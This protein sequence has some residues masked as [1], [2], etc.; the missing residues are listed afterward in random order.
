MNSSSSF[1]RLLHSPWV[2]LRSRPQSPETA[3]PGNWRLLKGCTPEDPLFFLGSRLRR[4]ESPAQRVMLSAR[5][6]SFGV[7]LAPLTAVRVARPSAGWP[8]LRPRPRATHRLACAPA[9][10]R[11][12]GGAAE[13][14]VAADAARTVAQAVRRSSVRVSSA[15]LVRSEA[16]WA[17]QNAQFGRPV[18]FRLAST[19]EAYTPDGC[20]GPRL[21]ASPGHPWHKRQVGQD[22]GA[23]SRPRASALARGLRVAAVGCGLALL[24]SQPSRPACQ[25]GVHPFDG[26]G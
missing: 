15:G 1:S 23:A 3:E 13:Q 8:A 21:L 22:A 4:A 2:D 20:L 24:A 16:A 11:C 17:Q 12:L 19:A 7:P 6:V 10:P 5:P 14:G 25:R 26:F 18:H 9:G